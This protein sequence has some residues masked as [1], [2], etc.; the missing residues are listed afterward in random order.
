[1]LT[2]HDICSQTECGKKFYSPTSVVKTTN[3]NH[4]EITIVFNGEFTHKSKT[5]TDGNTEKGKR[6]TAGFNIFTHI[7]K[8]AGMSRS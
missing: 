2:V 4:M 6:S 1:M 3:T 7:I 5:D 8:I